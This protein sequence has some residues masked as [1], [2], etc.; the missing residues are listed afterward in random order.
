[1]KIKEMFRNKFNEELHEDNVYKMDK[2]YVIT[3][4]G[5]TWNQAKEEIDNLYA[6]WISS[7][8]SLGQSEGEILSRIEK[9]EIF[10]EL[11]NGKARYY[12][13]DDISIIGQPF[14]IN[15]AEEEQK[16]NL[17][18]LLLYISSKLSDDSKYRIREYVRA[19]Q[20]A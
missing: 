2:Q 10:K 1:M 4:K 9:S 7:C 18:L 8:E 19:E 16:L 14:I 20:I 12:F 5:K 17:F 13:V 11:E 3:G 6:S 15:T